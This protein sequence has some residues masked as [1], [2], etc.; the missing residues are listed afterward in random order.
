[1]T[2]MKNEVGFFVGILT[3][4]QVLG[5]I[6]TNLFSSL[7]M[8]YYDRIEAGMALGG[9]FALL[10]FVLTPLISEP[11][12]RTKENEKVVERNAGLYFTPINP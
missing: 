3:V 5:Q 12:P 9:Y 7:L 11:P 8:V 4:V 1:M 2:V 6:V 10:G